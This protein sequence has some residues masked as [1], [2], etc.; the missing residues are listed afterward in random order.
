MMIYLLSLPVWNNVLP[1]YAYRHAGDS[2]WGQ[3][4]MVQGETAADGDK[5][6]FDSSGIV[7]K[8]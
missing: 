5:G 8:R 7:M 6:E 1:T 2:S 4:H 3:T